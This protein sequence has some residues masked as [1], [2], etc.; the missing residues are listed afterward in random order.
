MPVSFYTL[1]NLLERARASP[2][3]LLQVAIELLLIGLSVNWCAGVLHGTRGTRLLRGLLVMLVGVTLI[4]RVLSGQLGWTRLE[5][6]YNYFVIG[7]GFIALIAFQPEL[8]RALIQAGEVPFFRRSAPRNKLIAALT[9]CAAYC[10]ARRWGALVAIQRDVGLANWT[11]HGTRLDAE[12]SAKLLNS[13]FFPNS[14]LHDLGVIVRG[15]RV[16]AANCQFPSAEGGEM[17][18]GL[19]SRHRAAVGLSQESDALVLV[20]SEETGRISLAERGKLTRLSD[21]DSLESELVGR[22]GGNRD[23]S[24]P[25][26]AWL[27]RWSAWRRPSFWR[28]IGIVTPVSFVIWLLADQASMVTLSDVPIELNLQTDAGVAVQLQ[29]PATPDFRVDL[30]GSKRQIDAVRDLVRSGELR[31]DWRLPTPYA[32]PGEHP[33]SADELI[34]VLDGM[35]EIRRRGLFVTRV[36]PDRMQFMVDELTRIEL[37]LVADTGAFD[38]GAVRFEPPRARVLMRRSELERLPESER[39]LVVPLADRLA[40]APRGETLTLADVPLDA[41]SLRAERVEPRTA[42]VTLQVLTSKQTRRFERVDVRLSTQP[43]ILQ[44][45]SFEARDPNEWIVSLEVEGERGLVER[46][47]PTDLLAQVDVRP[48]QLAGGAEFRPFDVEVRLPAGVTLVGRP[49]TVYLR[50]APRQP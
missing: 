27:K 2:D 34:E 39:R 12:V 9:E 37:E 6:L 8:R 30:R 16:L 41:R 15:T 28:R 1:Q 46:L 45:Y 3:Q 26:A 17:E 5:L 29:Q 36:V 23:A 44:R 19:G 40:S 48:P 24:A 18:G 32:R 50:I 38:V 11:E 43:E 22:L 13:I 14:P 31:L 33:L 7:L 21:P 10:S 20:V 25:R 35:P 47:R 49:P 42:R 4:V